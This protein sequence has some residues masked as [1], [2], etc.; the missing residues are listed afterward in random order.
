MLFISKNQIGFMYNNLSNDD[1]K[2]VMELTEIRQH[3][4]DFSWMLCDYL[5]NN[6]CYITK[7]LLENVNS[8]L[9][10]SEETLYFTLLTGLFGLDVENNERDKQLANDYLRRSVK[11]LN[12]K[13]YAENPYYRDI[14]IPEVKFGNWELKYEKYRPYEAFI[15]DDI[16]VEKDLKEI[17]RIGFFNKEFRFPAVMENDHEWMAIKPNEIETMKSTIDVI[18]GKVVTFGLGLGYFSYMA[19]LKEN[20]Q[21]V[22]VV[23][24]NKEVIQLFEQYIL[25][26]F[27]YKEKV[28]II[29]I[30]AF[31]FAEKQMPNKNYDYAFVDLW[32]DVSDGL[33]LYLKIKKMEHFS[34]RTKFM[35]WIED[36]LLSSLR[37]QIFD[38]V[39]KNARSYNEIV[40]CLSK[41][42]LQ[43]LA[44]T[45][46]RLA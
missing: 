21:S 18:E 38:E 16:I 43:K 9:T 17:P 25:P 46:L 44:A 22:T 12:T 41:P 8:G 35:Y 6:P 14:I 5:N 42:F 30:D 28:K 45:T 2:K 13:S 36:S 15:Y 31:E 26:Q 10:L 29:S 32:H 40:E 3:N 33:D 1:I 11:Q 19:S 39:I 7:E 37:W 34:P 4:N 20:V 23:E 27:R 24:R